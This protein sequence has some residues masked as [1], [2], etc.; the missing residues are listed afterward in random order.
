MYYPSGNLIHSS[1][2][3]NCQDEDDSGYHTGN[4]TALQTSVKR[5]PPSAR[6]YKERTWIQLDVKQRIEAFNQ[7]NQGLFMEMVNTV[8]L[9]LC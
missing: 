1:G 3:F 6:T 2:V 7:N 4:S 5:R 8:V 9:S